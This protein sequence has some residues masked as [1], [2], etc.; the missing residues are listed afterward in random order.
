MKDNN[1]THLYICWWFYPR[2]PWSRQ[3]CHTCGDKDKQK[4]AWMT[5]RVTAGQRE[6]SAPATNIPIPSHFLRLRDCRCKHEYVVLHS[7]VSIRCHRKLCLPPPF[8]L[9]LLV[10][11]FTVTLLLSVVCE[12]T[13]DSTP[14]PKT[15]CS[16]P[17]FTTHAQTHTSRLNTAPP[18]GIFGSNTALRC[19]Q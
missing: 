6:G 16:R 19:C 15:I 17:V 3:S 12:Q 10:E 18:L 9:C 13:G 11:P 2:W 14:G 8:C 1:T 4:T 7:I 5:D